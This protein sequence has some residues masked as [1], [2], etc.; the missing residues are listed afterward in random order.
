MY[1]SILKKGDYHEVQSKYRFSIVSH[2]AYSYR[3]VSLHLVRRFVGS[4]SP[5][6]NCSRH[7]HIIEPLDFSTARLIRRAVTIHLI[8]N[9]KLFSVYI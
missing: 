6:C 1:P 5:P 9:S 8:K 3:L 7:L 4:I 2:L